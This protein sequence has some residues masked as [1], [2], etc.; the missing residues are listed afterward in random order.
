ML[1]VELA[2]KDVP[3]PAK[4]SL[5]VIQDPADGVQRLTPV[6]HFLGNI[7]G[8]DIE[9]HGVEDQVRE[10]ATVFHAEDLPFAEVCRELG[11]IRAF[12]EGHEPADASQ[13]YMFSPALIYQVHLAP[14][15]E[16]VAFF[17]IHQLASKHVRMIVHV[18]ADKAPEVAGNLR[19]VKP[20][21]INVF[22]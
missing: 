5:D 10:R 14:Q 4:F 19:E 11:L 7:I 12:L 13:L 2:H 18:H 9:K 6:A 3:I 21:A 1:R 16:S 17:P 15:F 8:E 20:N 22:H